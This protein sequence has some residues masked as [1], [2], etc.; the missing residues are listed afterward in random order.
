MHEPEPGYWM[1]LKV[2][3]GTQIRIGKDGKKIVEYLEHGLHDT[4]LRKVLS[5]SY[6]VFK[7]FY[8]G[9][10]HVAQ[11]RS[12]Q[13]LNQILDEFYTSYL[14]NLDLTSLDLVEAINGIHF[15]S[16][17]KST[18]LSVTSFI[19][20]LES[21]FS[22]GLYDYLT[23]PETG[24]LED[25]VVNQVKG[26]GEAVISSRPTDLRSQRSVS[27]GFS[28]SS[29]FA[30][31]RKEPAKFSGFL[32]GPSGTGTG[33]PKKLYVGRD[34]TEHEVLV[35]QFQDDCS[36]IMFMPNGQSATS[37]DAQR[38]R[39]KGFYAQ[40]RS[41]L[42]DRLTPLSKELAEGYTRSKKAGEFT[43]THYRYVYYNAMNL[44][45]KTSIGQHKSTAI[46]EDIARCLGALHEEFESSNCGLE[47]VCVKT[48]ADVWIVGRRSENREFYIVLPK[49]DASLTDV[50]AC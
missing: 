35:Y 46:T 39:D 7:L 38:P 12:P 16:L 44:A 47:E 24:K 45:F 15:L 32:V 31:L 27:G 25:G 30:P 42:D 20:D 41:F 8:K 3:L 11:T 22:L 26:K 5:R 28:A 18:Y 23:D 21:R 49:A 10:T 14:S 48:G 33:N 4:A 17:D 43:D 1:L 50:E 29:L 34:A 13:F 37:H 36:L 40:L 9:F 2:K 19:R 6:E